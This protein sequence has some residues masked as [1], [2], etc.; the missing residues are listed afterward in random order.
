MLIYD[1]KKV[2]I[3]L[4]CT[5]VTYFEMLLFGAGHNIATKERPAGLWTNKQ[6]LL[7]LE[8]IISKEGLIKISRMDMDPQAVQNLSKVTCCKISSAAFMTN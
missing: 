3:Y 6:F 5:L 7:L 4:K 2:M 8:H 1:K